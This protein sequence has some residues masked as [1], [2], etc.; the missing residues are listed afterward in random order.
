MLKLEVAEEIVRK[1]GTNIRY[2]V[3]VIGL[4]ASGF[5]AFIGFV[6]G[7]LLAAL[8]AAPIWNR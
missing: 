7:Y 4:G 6:S 8:V 3:R 2:K 1:R 5:W